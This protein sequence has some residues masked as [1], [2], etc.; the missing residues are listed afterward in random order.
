MDKF[1]S[2]SG[3][4]MKEQPDLVTNKEKVKLEVYLYLM[5]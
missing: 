2:I 1:S 5:I 3:Q 4:K